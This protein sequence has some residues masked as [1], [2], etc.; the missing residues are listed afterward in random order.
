M[1]TRSGRHGP[2]HSNLI[3]QNSVYLRS[4]NSQVSHRDRMA[5][6]VESLGKFLESDAESCPLSIAE[7]LSQGVRPIISLEMDRLR[8]GFDQLVHP[9]DRD[10]LT[11]RAAC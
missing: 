3:Q 2:V 5:G 7:S 6:M 1:I 9:L 4:L 10:G 8:P 11:S